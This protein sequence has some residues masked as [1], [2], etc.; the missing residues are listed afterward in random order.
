MDPV[1]K[2]FPLM[3]FWSDLSPRTPAGQMACDEA[4]LRLAGL[5]VLRLYRWSAPAVTFGYAQRL[6]VV[7]SIVG[8]RPLMRRWSGG[9]VVDHGSDLTLALAIPSS[10]EVARGGSSGIYR[11][12]HEALLGA[13]RS[14]VPGARLVTPE[15]CR[16][17]AVCF[18]SPVQCDIVAG[19]VKLCGGALRRSREGVL[20]QGSL[21]IENPPEQNIPA[22]LSEV[23]SVFQNTA[24]VEC[25]ARRLE[26]EKYSL[27]GWVDLR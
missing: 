14:A 1:K 16:C 13:I 9:G 15:E 19:A 20:Y 27:P 6:A 26:V 7:R 17:G 12:I 3:Q 11:A 8:D 23:C 2:L 22:S 24:P 21:V 18:Q 25:E 5:P 10:S 4:L